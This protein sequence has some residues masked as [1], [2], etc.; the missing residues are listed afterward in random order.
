ML[1]GV[2]AVIDSWLGGLVVRSVRRQRPVLRL[3][4]ARWIRPVVK[5]TAVR[6]RRS[7][8]RGALTLAVAAGIITL[9][10]LMQ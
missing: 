2:V 7:L 3:V 5:P 8:T 6:L 4:P 10:I 1:S 9:L